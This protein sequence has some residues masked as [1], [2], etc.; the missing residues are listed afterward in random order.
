VLGCSPDRQREG[1]VRGG[2]DARPTALYVARRPIGCRPANRATTPTTRATSSEISDTAPVA[3]AI[4]RSVEWLLRHPT[5]GGAEVE[6]QL[7]DRIDY[8]I[9]DRLA[10]I[11]RDALDRTQA[12]QLPADADC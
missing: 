12:L 4:A 3:E 8:D 11:Y 10:A 7:G 6:K 5:P 9:E 1:S 2:S